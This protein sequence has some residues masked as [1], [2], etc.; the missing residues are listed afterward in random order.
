MLSKYEV[1]KICNESKSIK[2]VDTNICKK[3]I[4]FVSMKEDI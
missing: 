1:N 2:N 4:V 3:K